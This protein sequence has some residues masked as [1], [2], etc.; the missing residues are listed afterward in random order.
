MAHRAHLYQLLNRMGLSHGKVT[1]IYSM[2]A[3][4]QGGAAI[5]MVAGDGQVKA[6]I[7]IPFFLGYAILAS[8][9]AH[10]AKVMGLI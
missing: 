2:L 6:W 10:R 7:L 4:L 1:A 9:L 3:L 8:C 5:F